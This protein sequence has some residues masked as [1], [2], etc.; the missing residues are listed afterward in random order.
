MAEKHIEYDESRLD[1]QLQWEDLTEKEMALH[2]LFVK[3]DHFIK[4]NAEKRERT[5]RKFE[6]LLIRESD[7]NSALENL[8]SKHKEL[9]HI[10]SGLQHQAKINGIYYRYLIKYIEEFQEF[11]T[12][13]EVLHRYMALIE[14][15]LRL[16]HRQFIDLDATEKIKTDLFLA[17][18][19]QNTQLMTI[20]N[21]LIELQVLGRT[22]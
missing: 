10:K 7:L 3:Y 20:Y 5:S 15:R 19:N 4:D 17:Y 6:E 12:P 2:G 8:I 1:L 9:E 21:R 11:K 16:G 13:M 22:T 14:T 18:N